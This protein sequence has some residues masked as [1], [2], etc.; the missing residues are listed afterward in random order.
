MLRG[1]RTLAPK[2]RAM[3]DETPQPLR[4]EQV[5]ALD[6]LRRKGTESTF[7]EIRGRVAATFERFA[8]LIDGLDAE[9]ARRSP[10]AGAWS[11]QEVVDHL[12][13]TDRRSLEQLRELLAG[14][15]VDDVIPASLQS[16]EPLATDWDSLRA[17][18]RALHAEILATLDTATDD[19]S[20][21]PASAPVVMVVQCAEP[22]GRLVPVHWGQRFDPKAYALIL[23]AHSRQHI[24]QIERTLAELAQRQ[25]PLSNAKF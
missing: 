7:D 4:P 12:L 20:L 14:R 1:G 6:Y 17:E 11:A 23:H 15:S 19:L 24:G 22:D 5:R 13:V 9:T 16:V 10:R 8:E 25:V 21:A 2:I 3:S 18:F